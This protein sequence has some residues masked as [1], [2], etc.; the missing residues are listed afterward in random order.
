ML[1]AQAGGTYVLRLEASSAGGAPPSIDVV[2]RQDVFVYRLA[3]YALIAVFA[4]ALLL[5]ILSY[6]FER[7]RWSDSTMAP[8][9]YTIR[10]GGDDE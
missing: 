6:S 8:S 7:R 2:V 9:I 10:A 5:V 4:P 3:L 1:P